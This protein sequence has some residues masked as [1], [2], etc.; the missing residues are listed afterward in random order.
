[1]E[2]TSVIKQ[3][4]VCGSHTHTTGGKMDITSKESSLAIQ[5]FKMH[6]ALMSKSLF[7]Q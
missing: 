3:L 6:E 1:M 5:K 2:I 7:V 4:K